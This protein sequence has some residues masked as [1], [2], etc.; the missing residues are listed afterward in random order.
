MIASANSNG[1][2]R[3][4]PGR[5][6][7]IRRCAIHVCCTREAQIG[8]P[9]P[10]N[11]LGRDAPNARGR[12]NESPIRPSA[13]RSFGRTPA[14]LTYQASAHDVPTGV[15]ARTRWGVSN[16]N[17]RDHVQC[18]PKRR[19]TL[20]F[21]QVRSYRQ[22]SVKPPA[23]AYVGSNP[24]PATH[25]P[26]SGPV[27]GP[28]LMCVRGRFRGPFPV[29][30]GQLRARSGQVSGLRPAVPRSRAGTDRAPGTAPSRGSVPAG[31]GPVAGICRVPLGPAAS[32]GV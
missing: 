13:I 10:R 11:R 32:P 25:N 28:G 3:T 2:S 31:H 8:C 6:A 27:C 5:L 7:R 14:L 4:S 12:Q 29:P 1:A 19:H 15:D 30:V 21:A 23:C 20:A 17:R 24:A 26:R 9:S 18:M 16:G 22:G